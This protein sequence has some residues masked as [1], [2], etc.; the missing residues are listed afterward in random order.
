MA[1]TT[2]RWAPPAGT[3]FFENE[4][5]KTIWRNAGHNMKYPVVY[6]SISGASVLGHNPHV[7]Q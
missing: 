2:T 5:K 1:A 6:A 3:I 7:K 4:A